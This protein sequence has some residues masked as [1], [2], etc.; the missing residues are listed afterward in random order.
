MGVRRWKD[1]WWGAFM[2]LIGLA[3]VTLLGYEIAMQ[4]RTSGYVPVP[5]TSKVVEVVR[6]RTRRGRLSSILKASYEY[7][8]AGTTH[9]G[10]RVLDGPN[11]L[12]AWT[13]GSTLR[14]ELAARLEAERVVYVDPA[15]AG[16]SALVRGI[17]GWMLWSA[18]IPVGWTLIAVGVLLKDG[19]G[20]KRGR[21]A[22]VGTAALAAGFALVGVT[23]LSGVMMEWVGWAP[24]WVDVAGTWSV[25]GVAGVVGWGRRER[26]R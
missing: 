5:V 20:A 13:P 15:D 22:G 16:R 11:I 17:E 6:T 18:P 10:F 26:K 1:V 7:E 3:G 23:I 24:G 14:R 4:A 9:A 21:G 8:V 2:G 19:I 12:L 25:G